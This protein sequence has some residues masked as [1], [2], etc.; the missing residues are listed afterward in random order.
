MS[1]ARLIPGNANVLARESCMDAIHS[2]GVFGWIE[3]SDIPFPHS[4]I[5]EPSFGCALSE[6]LAS[7]GFPFDGGD[8]GMSQNEVCE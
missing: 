8:W 3:Q 1:N 5:G 4:Q 7:V 2:S 6:D